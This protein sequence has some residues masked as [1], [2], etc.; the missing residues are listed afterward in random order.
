LDENKRNDI[1]SNL[2]TLCVSCHRKVH[3]NKDYKIIFK[4][5]IK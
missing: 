3:H 4:G 2:I 5:D 1:K